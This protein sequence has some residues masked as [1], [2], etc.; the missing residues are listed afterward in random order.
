M[1]APANQYTVN[2]YPVENGGYEMWSS[3]DGAQYEKDMQTAKHLGFN[4]MRVFLAAFPGIFDFTTPT[5]AELANLTDFY[6]RAVAV[7]IKLHLTLFDFW[8]DYGC[9][10]GSKIWIEAV[11]GALPNT[12]NIAVIEIQ[13]ETRFSLTTTYTG[14]F[15]AGWPAGTTKYNQLGQVAIVWAEQIIPYMRSVAP[16]IPIT[17]STSYG[18]ADLAAFFAAVNGKSAAPSWYDWHCYTGSSSLVYSALQETVSIVGNPAM[19]F[20]GETGLSS[21]A[22]GTQGTLQAQ[23]AQS[24]YIQAVRWS[25]AQLGLPE[26]APWILFDLND[27]AQFP[28]GQTYGLYETSGAGKL[29]LMM[30]ETNPPGTAVPAVTING[31]MQGGNQPDINGNGLPMRWCL[32][33]GQ[34]G[35]QPISSTI[36]TVNTYSG[37]PT[38]LLTG[39]GAT[40]SSDNSPALEVCPVTL[41]LISEGTSHKYSCALK[42]SGTYGSPF[43]EICWYDSSGNYISSTNGSVLTV[44]G[45]FI[46]YTLSSAAPTAA[47]YAR[48]FVNVRNNAGNIWVGGATWA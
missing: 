20:I 35:A 16:G 33:K 46:R 30:Y 2:Y 45:T 44:S 39:S 38:I 14:T 10:A 7:G 3:Y 5:A 43:L 11:L 29:A 41:P 42:A 27:S 15:D 36:D 22:T 18:T 34:Q 21:T 40:S 37:N 1:P 12:A 13:N 9:I 31:T 4:T 8:G 28:G 19:L 6:N 17:S 47:A 48:L 24:D 32:Y 25:C 26:P 23:Q